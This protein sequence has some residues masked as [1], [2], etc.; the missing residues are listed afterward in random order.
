M[1]SSSA[2]TALRGVRLLSADGAPSVAR[3]RFV[4]VAGRRWPHAAPRTAGLV[5]PW[6]A[7]TDDRRR[8]RPAIRKRVAPHWGDRLPAIRSTSSVTELIEKL[9]R[10]A[11]TQ[12]GL[13]RVRSDMLLTGAAAIW[14]YKATSR[15]HAA[16]FPA[17]CGFEQHRRSLHDGD[18]RCAV[19]EYVSTL[20][21]CPFPRFGACS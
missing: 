9:L 8:R 1:V 13:G 12:S 15:P 20:V 16:K 19:I 10:S 18:S 4:N 2:R 5:A 14:R 17:I 11:A 21:I 3:C 7:S 6:R